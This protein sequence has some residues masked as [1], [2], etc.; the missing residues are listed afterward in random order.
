MHL[1]KKLS[2]FAAMLTIA[3]CSD[4]PLPTQTI[5][6]PKE[7]EFARHANAPADLLTNINVT[8]TL[9]DGSTLAGLLTITELGLVDGALVA[10]GTLV[11][12][13]TS[14]LG[15]VTQFTQTFTDTALSLIGSA[16]ACDIL[17]LDLG[18]IFLDLLGLQVDLSAINLDIVAQSGPGNLLGNLLCAVAHLLDGPGALAGILNILGQINSILG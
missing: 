3:A 17:T 15:V 16:G 18:P 14:P 1:G 10:T 8:Q 6:A 9:A 13:V 12:T 2:L 7:A 5:D 4:Q 11:G